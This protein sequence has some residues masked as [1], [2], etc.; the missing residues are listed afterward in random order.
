MGGE[1]TKI[2]KTCR[3]EF[4]VPPDSLVLYEKTGI[5]VPQECH[6][7]IWKNLTAFWVFGKFRKTTSA[8]SGKTIITTFSEKTPFPLY[9]YDEWMSDV[10]D[11]LQYG[12][13]YDFSRPFFEQ[14]AEVQRKTPHPHRSGTMS[15]NCDWSDDA[16]SCKN[17][18]LCRSMLDCEE[19]N[20]AYRTVN[21][22]NS[23]DLTFCFDVERSYDCTYCFKSYKVRHSFDARDSMDSAFLYDC[24][25]VKNC[26]MCWN[27]RNKQYCILNKQYSK[28]GYF[29]KMKEY[30]LNSRREVERLKKEFAD[31]VAREVI[32]KADR[33]LK[34]VDSTGN[35]LEEC[36]NC[37]ESYFAQK[38]EN[39]YYL[40]RGYEQ[41]E[42][43]HAAGTIAENAALSMMD[44]YNYGT[45]A[46]SRC[47]NCR[48]S[49]YLEYCE[50]CEY[51]FGCVGLRKKKYC[52]L[53][54]Q[55]S[56]SE[57]NDLVKKI[58]DRMTADGT[59]GTFFPYS[60]AYCGYN[61]STGQMYF[62]ETR[63][64]IEEKGGLWEDIQDQAYEGI[65][66]D[67]V[68]DVI[69]GVDNDFSKQAIVCP[70]TKWRFNIAPQELAFYKEQGIPLPSRHP[71]RRNL[72]RMKPLT[73]TTP[74]EGMCFFC[75][76]PI[77]H[78]Y[79]PEWGY[80]KIVCEECYQ[81]RVL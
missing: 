14:Y 31:V 18:Y 73:V 50:E 8:L 33:N 37:K 5:P 76:R 44:G 45:V 20:Y 74:Y 62:P 34:V 51:C 75:S 57:Y 63:E 26:F 81:D 69:D 71:D 78:Y 30:R 19:V 3:K 28:E 4:S 59:W 22:K 49:A 54:K 77:I 46:T 60:L 40:L 80:Q 12:R 10:W 24:R 9:D 23:T 47:G 25:N 15:T 53:N 68:P 58:K 39:G 41:R 79:P 21:C 38:S 55:Y 65:S 6:V 64:S 17:C 72:E 16:W 35:F 61:L 56:E 11:P 67:E 32:H 52:I 27:L 48:Y 43:V 29:E 36:K 2:C 13:S 1:E 70:E 66:G 7:C 42:V